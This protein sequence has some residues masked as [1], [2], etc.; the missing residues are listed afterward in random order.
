MHPFEKIIIA[1][2]AGGPLA[3]AAGAAAFLIGLRTVLKNASI[4]SSNITLTIG[5]KITFGFCVLVVLASILL[6]PFLAFYIRD[7]IFALDLRLPVQI[8][9]FGAVACSH[10]IF[11]CPI[12]YIAPAAFSYREMVVTRR[13][14]K[15]MAAFRLL[16]NELDRAEIR[17]AVLGSKV[18][19]DDGRKFRAEFT[20]RIENV[21]LIIPKYKVRIAQAEPMKYFLVPFYKSSSSGTRISREQRNGVI[22]AKNRKGQW[23]FSD[24]ATSTLVGSNSSEISIPVEIV[25]Q[26]AAGNRLPKTILVSLDAQKAKHEYPLTHHFFR[27]SFP[28]DLE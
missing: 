24:A 21:P 2:I 18:V 27:K 17:V 15:S 16:M 11:F 7:S 1:A 20:L 3:L 26:P 12:Y 23:I 10:V 19:S 9:F 8:L 13:K 14:E 4:F 22:K 6:C 25:R 28:V 5:E